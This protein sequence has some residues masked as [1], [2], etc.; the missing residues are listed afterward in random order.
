[1]QQVI[2]EKQTRNLNGTLAR[3]RR[4]MAELYGQFWYVA[5]RIGKNQ[6]RSVTQTVK[7]VKGIFYS[8]WSKLQYRQQNTDEKTPAR[9]PEW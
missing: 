4:Q 1:V 2:G 6:C 3:N 5:L 8:N 9:Q 7:L